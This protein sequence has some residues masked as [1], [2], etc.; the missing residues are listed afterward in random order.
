[1]NGIYRIPSKLYFDLW[2]KGNELPSLTGDKLLAVYSILKA[3]RNKEVKYYAYKS[4]NNKTISGYSLLRAKTNM[5]LHVIEKYVPTLIE[6]GLCF[7]DNNGDFVLLGNQYV[8]DLY[9]SYKLIP[10]RIGKNVADTALNVMSVRAFANEGEQQKQ[11]RKKLTRSVIISQGI[12]P[13]NNK[14]L[15]DAKTTLKRFG[16]ITYLNEKTVL[17]NGGFGLLKHGAK[18]NIKNLKS[19]GS[20][21]KRKLK[22]KGIIK[23]QRQFENIEKMP[24]ECYLGLKNLGYL[25]NRQTYRNGFLVNELPSAFSTV[26]LVSVKEVEIPAEKEVKVRN[27][28]KKKQY[29]QFDIIDFWMNSDKY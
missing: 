13:K 11:Y 8:K 23:T 25:E 4:K 19:S 29:L 15:R 22:S 16:E 5:S 2:T 21:W 12:D 6:I 28:Y 3:G 27:D 18:N 24:Y 1:M 10:I 26:R 14:K 7:I 9:N 17:S 20:Y